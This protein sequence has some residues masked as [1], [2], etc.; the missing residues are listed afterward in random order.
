MTAKQGKTMLANEIDVSKIRYS[1]LKSLENGG[2]ISYVNYGDEGLNS[3]YLQTPELKFPFDSLFYTEGKDSGKF[4]CKVSLNMEGSEQ[5]KQFAE[6]MMEIDK[7]LISDAQKNSMPWF[8]KKTMSEEVIDEK[9]TPIVRHYKDPE[10]GEMTGKFPAQMGFKV[11]QRNGK[12]QCKFFDESAKKINVD[13]S[14]GENYQE[15]SNLLTKGASVKLLLKCNGLWF[16]P[17]GFGCTWKAE[18]MKIKVPE[19]LE[20]YAFRDDGDGFVEDS[21]SDGGSGEDEE[22]VSEDESA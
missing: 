5:V 4:A 17:S 8:K 10:S 9:Y 3:I 12:F 14:E 11:V 13:N 19:T 7:K 6:K 1:D 21:D 16:S 15:V 2:K 20:E 22:V 18:Q